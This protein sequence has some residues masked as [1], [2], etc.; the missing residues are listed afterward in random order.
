MKPSSKVLPLYHQ[1]L[2]LTITAPTLAE[3]GNLGWIALGAILLAL[4]G[5]ALLLRRSR[6]RRLLERH[7]AELSALSAASRAIV[8]S[9]LD[10]DQLCTLIYR[11]ASQMVDTRTFQLGLFVDGRYH[12]KVWIKRGERQPETT[13]DLDGSEGIIGWMRATGQ[14]LLVRDF[15]TDALPAQPSYLSSD[16]PRSAVFVPLVAG[17]TVIGAMAIQSDRPDAFTAD[18]QRTLAI[19]A[20]QAAA[21]IS[22]ARLYEA[23]QRRR[24][25][26][27][28]LRQI[29]VEINASLDI[30]DVLESM[31]EG[32]A[33]LIPYDAAAILFLQDRTLTLRAARGRPPLT[34]AIGQSWPLAACQRLRWL[35]KHRQATLFDPDQ[36]GGAY[37][38]LLNFPD[39]HSCL[40]VPI[41]IRDEWI[42]ALMVEAESSGQY[43]AQDVETVDTLATQAAPALENARLYATGQEEAW[44]S[45]ALLE[46]AE[47]TGMAKSVDEVLET[48]V[49]ITP[50][51][52][53]VDGCYVLLWEPDIDA[54][55]VAAAYQENENKA[56]LSV[57]QVIPPGTWTLLDRLWARGSPVVDEFG[58]LPDAPSTQDIETT[59]LMLP[60][61]AQGELIGAMVIDFTGQVSFTQHRIKLIAGI[62]N[63]AALAI[64]S[65]QLAAAQQEEAWVSMA[66]LQVAE[67]VGTL[68]ELDDVLAVVARLTPLLIGVDR[69][70][71]YLW[72]ETHQAYM[73]GAAF[74]LHGERLN[75]F[76]AMSIPADQWPAMQVEQ[77][78][79]SPSPDAPDDADRLPPEALDAWGQVPL[80]P[81]PP[82]P[83]AGRLGLQAPLALPLLAWGDVMGALVV[84]TQD[85]NTP[86][87]DRRRSILSGV[88]QQT[89]TAIQNAQLHIESIER[90]KLER[91][92]ELARQIQVSCLPAQAPQTPGWDLSAYWRGA[93][94]V[95]GDFYDFI[96]LNE[97]EGKPQRWGFVVADVADKGVPA[98]LFMALSRTL[99]RTMAINGDPPAEVLQRANDLILADA[100]SDLFVTL[101]YAILDIEQGTLTYANGGHNPPLVFDGRV[102]RI[103]PL[104]APGMAL[105]IV[106]GIELEEREIALG[107]GDT[108]LFYTDGVTDALNDEVDEF[109]LKRLRRVVQAH[110][111]Q[112]A[113]D[114]VQAVNRAVAE[115]VGD[116]PQFDDFT[117]LVLKRQP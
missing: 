78:G 54:Y 27:D 59:L 64:E 35:V 82:R 32:L 11:Q 42:G 18:H 41:L 31:L 6:S 61:R 69:C 100:R 105:G 70:L 40:G 72:E 84:D 63:Q 91:E 102:D 57:G 71:I 77:I 99:V 1:V 48:V 62:A 87:A 52:V 58:S 7:V 74:G 89:A 10:V 56:S 60:L 12:I 68:S 112:S 51:L 13:F 76:E 29:S 111:S 115:F 95:S 45:T 110:Q 75:I 37:H 103:T 66:L 114:I 22:H 97:Q 50:M 5:S 4:A 55:H 85:S 116:T 30:D 79:A 34:E 92:I 17:E 47:A 14:S 19:V 93:R 90:Q 38:Q 104:A 21:A 33:R 73:P 36:T 83:V 43:D 2:Q 25:I 26:A 67:A 46:V 88:A 80:V 49:R 109:G 101:F 3:D 20:N 8:E 28:R 113:A 53:G 96:P 65:A 81:G 108:V 106:S 98:A 9:Q 94:Q 117:L 15:E 16:P 107:P 44:I 39:D 24:R 86:L 23:E